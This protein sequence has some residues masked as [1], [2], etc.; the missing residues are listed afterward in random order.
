MENTEIQKFRLS[1]LQKNTLRLLSEKYNIN[2][3]Q[4]IRD[5]ISEKLERERI[6][7]KAV[8]KVEKLDCPF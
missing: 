7:I 3:S 4:F 8:G 2:T 6:K 5:A 1:K